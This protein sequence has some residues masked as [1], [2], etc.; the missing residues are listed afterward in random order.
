MNYKRQNI[1]K[2]YTALGAV[3]D[4]TQPEIKTKGKSTES[5]LEKVTNDLKKIF[6]D[7][8]QVYGCTLTYK[9]KYHEEYPRDLHRNTYE[10]IMKSRIWKRNKVKFYL[11]PDFTK[12][13]IL[14]YHGIIYNVYKVDAVSIMKWWRRNYGFAKFED[15][16]KYSDKWIQ[17]ITKDV[18]TTG[19][20]PVVS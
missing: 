5:K 16:I 7:H 20:W 10:C 11:I 18:G 8:S 4:Q 9:K 19:L 14:H 3:L 6:L 2:F 12:K 15:N 17:Y 13:G 1:L